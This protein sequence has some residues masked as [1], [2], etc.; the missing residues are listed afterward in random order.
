MGQGAAYLE[1]MLSGLSLRSRVE[2][3]NGEN[4]LRWNPVVSTSLWMPFAKIKMRASVS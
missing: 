4:L 1:L 2:E 3:I